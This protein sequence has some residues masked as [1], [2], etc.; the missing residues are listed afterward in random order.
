MRGLILSACLGVLVAA[1][2]IAVTPFL[3]V[4]HGAGMLIPV[5]VLL[6][7]GSRVSRALAT[8]AVSGVILDCYALSVPGFY[9]FRICLFTIG[10]WFIFKH[11]LTN[12]S[13]YTAVVLAVLMTITD[14]L[15]RQGVYSLQGVPT[16]YTWSWQGVGMALLWNIFLSAFGFTLV[17]S[18]TKRFSVTIP[19]PSR[20]SWYG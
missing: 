17:A 1:W 20:T 7:M 10:A 14:V 6:L 11:W 15:S 19:D 12:R 18:L 16:A 9:V 4:S 13:V 5:L 2:E 3:F 8:A